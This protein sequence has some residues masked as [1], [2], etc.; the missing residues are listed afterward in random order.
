MF[1]NFQVWRDIDLVAR[2]YLFRGNVEDIANVVV[3]GRGHA[4]HVNI[5]VYA[6]IAIRDRDRA[7]G[8]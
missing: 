1:I 6:T 8:N 2:L 7:R 3:P 5:G 4:F